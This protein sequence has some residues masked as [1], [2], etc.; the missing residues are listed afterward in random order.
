MHN[1]KMNEYVDLFREMNRPKKPLKLLNP[2]KLL[3]LYE[4]ENSNVQ[5]VLGE[6][7]KV[8]D[9]KSSLPEQA[10]KLNKAI[11]QEKLK[12]EVTSGVKLTRQQ[13]RAAERAADRVNKV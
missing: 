5:V 6:L 4:K 10:D 11:E 3:P 2:E 1:S 8:I 7:H 12:K 9:L 13:K